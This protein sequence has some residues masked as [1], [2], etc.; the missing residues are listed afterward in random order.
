MVVML[1]SDGAPRAWGRAPT[2]PAAL[3]EAKRQLAEYVAKKRA[4]GETISE[5]DFKATK[6]LA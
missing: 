5:S 2:W 6:V 3:A 4:L 1:D